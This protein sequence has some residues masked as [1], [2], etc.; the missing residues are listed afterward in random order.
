MD[1]KLWTCYREQL[2]L[3]N[4]EESYAKEVALALSKEALENV[5]SVE[6]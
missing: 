4:E 5:Q 6:K 3:A 2:R 1:A